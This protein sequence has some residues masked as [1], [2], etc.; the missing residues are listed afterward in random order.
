METAGLRL[1]SDSIGVL[2]EVAASLHRLLLMGE[3]PQTAAF[4]LTRRLSDG[5][6][7][8]T[9][10]VEAIT[11]VSDSVTAAPLDRVT[12]RVG[13]ETDIFGLMEIVRRIESDSVMAIEELQVEASPIDTPRSEVER[14]GVSLAV[15]G[16]YRPN[17]TPPDTAS[18]KGGS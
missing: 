5:L 1:L 8:S 16:W 15:S 12:V 17:P 18:S 4:D 7:K 14:L 6:S 2:E 10:F 13:L 9:A 11:P 3:D